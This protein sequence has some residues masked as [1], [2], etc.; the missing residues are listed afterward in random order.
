MEQRYRSKRLPY[1]VRCNPQ[2]MTP[3]GCVWWSMLYSKQKRWRHNGRNIGWI[4]EE[5]KEAKYHSLLVKWRIDVSH[6]Q[7]TIA[8]TRIRR[9]ERKQNHI[10]RY[11]PHDVIGSPLPCNEWSNELSKSWTDSQTFN[12]TIWHYD[13]G[14]SSEPSLGRRAQCSREVVTPEGTGVG[15]G[16]SFCFFTQT[17]NCRIRFPLA[18][19]SSNCKLPLIFIASATNDDIWYAVS[20]GFLHSRYKN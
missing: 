3:D 14:T 20:S 1:P 16:E 9:I 13:K 6:L 8:D 17:K 7:L 10:C 2:V 11:L 15:K 18:S 5:Y 19:Q 4:R 12:S